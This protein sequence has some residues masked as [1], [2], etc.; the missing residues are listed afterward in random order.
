MRAVRQRHMA[1][2]VLAALVLAAGCGTPR[3]IPMPNSSSTS[4]VSSTSSQGSSQGSSSTAGTTT[5]SSATQANG[6]QYAQYFTVKGTPVTVKVGVAVSMTAND[7]Y[8][9]PNALTVKMGTTVHLDIDNVASE[10]H[11]FNLPAFGVNTMNLPTGTTTK[12]TFTP[13]R[14]GTYYFWC[15]LPGHAEA[16]MV[17]RLIVN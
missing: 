10:P 11:N 5:T 4:G 1:A 15:S 13:N 7:F 16:G 9:S 6:A 3:R 14:A 17:G 12:V 8:F 2:L